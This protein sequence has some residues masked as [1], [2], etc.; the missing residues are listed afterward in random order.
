MIGGPVGNGGCSHE[1]SREWMGVRGLLQCPPG[2]R[3]CRRQGVD[4]LEK[5]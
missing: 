1:C 3:L 2:K 4:Q 5:E